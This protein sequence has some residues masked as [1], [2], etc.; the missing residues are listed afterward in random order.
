MEMKCLRRIC[1]VTIRDRIRNE[2]IRRRVGVENDLS[3][4]VERCVLR[5][6]RHVERM[7]DDRMAKMVHVSGVDGRRGRGRPNR[8]WMDGVKEALNVRGWTLE[9]ARVNV[10]DRNEW[11]RVVNGA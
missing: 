8:V 6:Y 1:G 2:E 4:R 7:N 9:Q 5:W 10:H 11:K 3:G